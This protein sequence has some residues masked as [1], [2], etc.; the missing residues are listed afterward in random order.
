MRD[1]DFKDEQLERTRQRFLKQTQRG[2]NELMANPLPEG[3]L[4]RFIAQ[5]VRAERRRKSR[6]NTGRN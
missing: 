2:I 6:A 3:E 1:R 5:L 4:N